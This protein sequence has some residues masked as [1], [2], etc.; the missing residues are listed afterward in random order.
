MKL[1]EQTPLTGLYVAALA[2]EVNCTIL[3]VR[4]QRLIEIEVGYESPDLKPFGFVSIQAL[5]IYV[6]NTKNMICGKMYTA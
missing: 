1:A 4:Q 2:A 3:Y 5:T 6:G